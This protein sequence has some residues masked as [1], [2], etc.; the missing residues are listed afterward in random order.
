M[1][2]GLKKKPEEIPTNHASDRGNP[3]LY[4]DQLWVGVALDC[5]STGTATLKSMGKMDQYNHNKLSEIIL[6]MGSANEK[7]RYIVT[8]SFIG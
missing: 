3:H 2:P 4:L 7:Q 8:L 1:A 6:G 5:A